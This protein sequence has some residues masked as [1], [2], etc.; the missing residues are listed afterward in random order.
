MEFG[1]PIDGENVFVLMSAAMAL[2]A[3]QRLLLQPLPR[4]RLRLRPRQSLLRLRCLARS[5][6]HLCD[7]VGTR[8]LGAMWM[9][10]ARVDLELAWEICD[11]I[12]MDTYRFFEGFFPT[13]SQPQKAHRVYPNSFVKKLRKKSIAPLSKGNQTPNKQYFLTIC[14][15]K[16]LS[17]P[18][19]F[20][21]QEKIRNTLNWNIKH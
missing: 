13:I 15:K 1:Q 7:L 11:Q 2:P 17:S 21:D 8:F 10:R 9:I 20:N 4:L 19:F 18:Q 3:L 5:L 6:G 16:N 12:L 14:E